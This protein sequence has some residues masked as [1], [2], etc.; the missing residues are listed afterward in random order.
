MFLQLAADDTSVIPR[1]AR[2]SLDNRLHRRQFIDT[3]RVAPDTY[4]IRQLVHPRPRFTDLG[5]ADLEQM[6]AA[7]AVPA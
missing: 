7:I 1:R 3:E 6:L 2:N 4:V 5:Q